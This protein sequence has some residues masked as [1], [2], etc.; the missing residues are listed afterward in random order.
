M[1]ITWLDPTNKTGAF[2]D[3]EKALQNPEGLLAAGGDLSTTRL[4]NAYKSGIFPWYEDGQPILWWSPNPRGVLF[5]KNLRISTSLKKIL[6]KHEWTVTF[7]GDFKKTVLACAAPRSYARGTWIT[8]EMLEAYTNLHKKGYA[9]S[10]ELWDYQERL[11]GG[12]YGVL[13]GTM[14]YG[15]SMFSFQT[16][17]SKVALVY[18]VTHL[19]QW[20]F[21][22]LDCQL[23][24][25]HLNSLGAESISRREYIKTMTPLS[26]QHQ[27]NLTWALDENLDVSTWMPLDA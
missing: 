13:I 14:F 12:I 17:A 18:L 1:D 16:N 26:E 20:G 27:K 23:P 10:V 9:H 24:S 15:E 19:H 6:R 7:D 3:V 4:L 8:N 21:P 11:I 25:A 22:L 2:P 5:T